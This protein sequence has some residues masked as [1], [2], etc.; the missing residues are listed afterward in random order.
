M[1]RSTFLLM[2][3]LALLVA[4]KNKN[5]K[6]LTPG[7]TDNKEKITP[8]ANGVQNAIEDAD[9]IKEELGKLSPLAPDQLKALL[10]S[11]IGG[12]DRKEDTVISSMGAGL[13]TALYPLNDST[14]IKLSIYDCA[15]S[16][17]AGIYSMQY[18]S[19]WETGQETETDYTRMIDF[20]GGKAFEHCDKTSGNCS[21]TC[22]S[23]GR[24]LIMFDG[25]HTGAD[26]LKQAAGEL[27]LK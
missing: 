23:G 1:K 22:F 19:L 18:L 2:A 14:S 24:F 5:G 13:A 15:G 9:K 4:C 8:S 10:P 27:N 7:A 3:W 20:K 6:E 21:F 16:A 17:G 12:A 26:L 25:D 11:T